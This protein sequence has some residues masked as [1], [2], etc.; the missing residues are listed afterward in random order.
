MIRLF[1]ERTIS[2]I[3]VSFRGQKRIDKALTLLLKAAGTE[4]D[5]GYW[6]KA[7]NQLKKE[8]HGKCA[9]CEASTAVV[10]HGDVEHFRPKSK[11]WWLAYCYDNYLFSCQLCNQ[12]FKGNEFP[13]GDETLM[14]AAPV[15][16]AT[17]TDAAKIKLVT[18]MS[19]DPLDLLDAA[20]LAKY[21]TLCRNEGATLIN[22]YL[23]DPEEH[24]KWEV[25][26]LSRKVSISEKTAA[27]KPFFEAADKFYGLNREDLKLERGRI[28][29]ILSAFARSLN[30]NQL[31]AQLEQEIK[32]EIQ[33]MIEPDALFAG[34]CRYFVREEWQLQL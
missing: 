29:R 2:A 26:A 10:A 27:S 6:K 8:S 16:A 1:R 9:Y 17:A 22:P 15:L 13:L 14:F 5:S 25:N 11:Y 33:A 3:P 21:E 18:E 28:Y 31:D 24:F 19:P 12:S 7:K 34:M 20:L 32:D 23:D 30:S 4:F